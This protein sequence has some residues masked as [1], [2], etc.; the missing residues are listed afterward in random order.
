MMSDKEYAYFRKDVEVFI[1]GVMEAYHLDLETAKRYIQREV[2]LYRFEDD[3]I[4]LIVNGGEFLRA[5]G[6]YGYWDGK[7]HEDDDD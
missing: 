2:G 7:F 1:K 6:Y 4:P 5:N 3:E